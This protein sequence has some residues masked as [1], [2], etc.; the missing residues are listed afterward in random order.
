VFHCGGVYL[1]GISDAHMTW[2]ISS[3]SCS[4]I[5]VKLQR[6]WDCC[7][8]SSKRLLDCSRRARGFDCGMAM[9]LVARGIG[10]C[11]I[12]VEELRQRGIEG[13]KSNRLML[14]IMDSTVVVIDQFDQQ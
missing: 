10:T 1:L 11:Q 14:V 7:I 9:G 4:N 8:K 2:F 3:Q 12:H 5:T 6:A 13:R